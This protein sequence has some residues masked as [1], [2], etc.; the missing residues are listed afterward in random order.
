MKSFFTLKLDSVLLRME[1]KLAK[2]E[3]AIIVKAKRD[4]NKDIEDDDVNDRKKKDERKIK[5]EKK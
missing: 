5:K 2:Q 1:S 4:E 3:N